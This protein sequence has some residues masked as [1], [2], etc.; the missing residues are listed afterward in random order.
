MPRKKGLMLRREGWL[1]PSLCRFLLSVAGLL[2]GCNEGS[3]HLT[4]GAVASPEPNTRGGEATAAQVIHFCGD[5]HATP[6][7]SSF[8]KA[9]W[10]RE[11]TRGYDLYYESGRGD[12]TVPLKEDVIRFYERLAPDKLVVVPPTTVS[13]V[14]PGKLL[15]RQQSSPK[16]RIDAPAVSYLDW[17]T[18]DSAKPALLLTDMRSGELHSID[19]TNA[20]LSSTRMASAKSLAHVE[21]CDLDGDGQQE[22]VCAELGSISSGDHSRGAIIWL[23]PGDPQGEWESTLLMSGLGRVS[24]VQPADFDQDGDVDLLVAEFGHLRTGSIFV[25]ENRGLQKLQKLVPEFRRHDIDNRH[26]TIHIPVADLN[27]DGRLDFV[28]L[29]SQEYETVV[30]FLSTGK[31]QF[32]RKEI[33]RATDPAFGSSCIDLVD[34]DRDGDLDVVYANGDTFGSDSL[35]PYHAVHWLENLGGYPFTEHVL[36]E[37]VGVQAARAIDLDLDGDLDIVAGALMPR[38]LARLPELAA[39]DSLLWLEQTN[40]GQFVRHSLERGDFAHA[41][42]CPADFDRDGD[43]DIAVGNLQD[44]DEVIRPWLNVWW[45]LG[46]DSSSAKASE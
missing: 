14:G 27:G 17:L 44:D 45:N 8:P 43:I 5:C 26:G 7:A 4:T 38:H 25:L 39:H 30:A 19:V 31:W 21:A 12:L 24:D 1:F 32:E 41:A 34:L 6:P 28:A 2:S 40:R 46:A 3:T 35:K 11:V 36:A 18:I 22:L 33:Y 9:A 16:P 10:P 29:I 37:M 13:D 20:K 23:R 15:F 42:V